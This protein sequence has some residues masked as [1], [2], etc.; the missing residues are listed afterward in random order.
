M[1]RII[2]ILTKNWLLVLIILLGFFLRVYRFP[3]YVQFLADQ[4]RD[5]IILKRIVTLEHLPAIGPPTSLGQIYLGP[6]YYYFI[7]PWLLIFN[8]NPLG[9]AIGVLFFST[10]FLIINYL[11]IK[12]LIDKKTALFSTILISFSYILIE[13]SRFSWNP[14]LLPLF[15]LLTVYFFIKSLKTHQWYFYLLTGSFLSFVIQLHY[16]AL[17]LIPSI[18]L[19]YLFNF[20]INNLKKYLLA[21]FGFI[22]FSL[23]LLIFDL[24]HQFLNSKNFIKFFTETRTEQANYLN[25]FFESFKFLNQYLFNINF[26]FWLLLII[27]I[28][29]ITSL[30]S[31]FNSRN[32]VKFFILIFLT[33]LFFY[34]FYNGPKHPHYFGILFP[35]YTVIISY[36][37]S[38]ITNSLLEKFLA[39]IF[40]SLFIFFNFQK[41]NFLFYKGSNQ[42]EHAKKVAEFINNKITS[43][44]FNFAV[45]PDGWQEDS[46][47]YFLELKNKR[48]LDR[49][50]VEIGEEMFVICGNKCDLYNTQSWNIKMFGDFRIDK[51]WNIENI[52]VYKLTH[53]Y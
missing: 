42:V 4:G 32:N 23:P 1:T 14:N 17:F 41:Y 36:F 22:F 46:Y 26:N 50:K 10:I 39:M 38:F 43:K 37:I 49:K 53:K 18:T 24:R 21:T 40:I 33:S 25:N 16:L 6:F 44:K 51:K 15:T 29:L 7:A 20:K 11:I 27:L 9:P 2:N 12:E 48:P 52:E 5:A 30:I 28:L 19:I 45:Q 8:F 3:E 47:L 34:S 35:L 31:I 13:F